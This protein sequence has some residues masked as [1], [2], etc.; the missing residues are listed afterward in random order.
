LKSGL[1]GRSEARPWMSARHGLD[2]TPYRQ[3]SRRVSRSSDFEDWRA[4][5]SRIILRPEVLGG[6]A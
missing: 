5:G 3:V 4:S 6:G 2:S 1:A